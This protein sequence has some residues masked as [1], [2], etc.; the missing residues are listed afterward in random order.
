MGA[1]LL[2]DKVTPSC[3]RWRR[4]W[5]ES[6]R[7][8]SKYVPQTSHMTGCGVA[9]ESMAVDKVVSFVG[10]DK[11]DFLRVVSCATEVE[12]DDFN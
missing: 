11:V 2:S 8:V 5:L 4:A 10:D 12:E 6:P 1:P 9:C 3:R 7:R